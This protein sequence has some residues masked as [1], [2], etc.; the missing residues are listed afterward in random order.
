V[1]DALGLAGVRRVGTSGH[2]G[3]APQELDLA[4]PVALV[5][6]R[7]AHG[8]PPEVETLLDDRASLPMK[9]AVESLNVAVAGSVLA[10]EVVRQRAAST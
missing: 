2:G 10:F 9:G 5:L 4:G 1:L 8:L 7:E 6:G 3:V